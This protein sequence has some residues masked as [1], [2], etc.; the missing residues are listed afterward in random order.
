MKDNRDRYILALGSVI[1]LLESIENDEPSRVVHL[2]KRSFLH[3]R[4][5]YCDDFDIT[6]DQDAIKEINAIVDSINQNRIN[7]TVEY[8]VL[9]P[10]FNQLIDKV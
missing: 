10:L 2:A 5:P 4:I 6:T 9:K 7:G 3:R 1:N 8:D